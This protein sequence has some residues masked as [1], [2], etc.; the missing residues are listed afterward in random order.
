M[1]LDTPKIVSSLLQ[2]GHRNF[3]VLWASSPGILCAPLYIY[4]TSIKR[5]IRISAIVL[6]LMLV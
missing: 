6:E 4:I 1:S 3:C 2:V 5:I